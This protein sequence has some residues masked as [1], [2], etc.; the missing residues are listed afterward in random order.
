MIY[1]LEMCVTLLIR[2]N[3]VMSSVPVRSIAEGITDRIIYTTLN[4]NISNTKSLYFSVS[5]MW[6]H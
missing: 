6:N 5:G 3:K 4:I 2:R 1:A